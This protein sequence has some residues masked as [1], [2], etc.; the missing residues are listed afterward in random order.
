[1]MLLLKSPLGTGF[2]IGLAALT[3]LA[4]QI[5]IGATQKS[6]IYIKCRQLIFNSTTFDWV[7]WIII[8]G[9]LLLLLIVL[10]LIG[11]WFIAGV[12]GVLIALGF[13]FTIDA[14][15]RTERQVP[16]Q[17][18][19]AMLKQLRLRGLD[20]MALEQFVCLYSGNKWE[21]FFEALFGYT[22]KIKA[23]NL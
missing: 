10:E 21:E 15:V 19:E 22:A 7:K 9:S 16:L 14:L 12:V 1:A 11:R 18:T 17:Q 20:E 23:R 8:V 3:S 13:A 4:Y 6:F 5:I 2:F